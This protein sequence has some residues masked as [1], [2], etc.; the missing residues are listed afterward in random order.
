MEKRLDLIRLN[1][2]GRV[3]VRAWRRIVERF[4]S[5]AEA[6]RAPLDRLAAVPGIGRDVAAAIHLVRREDAEREVERAAAAGA[7]LVA[8]E[9]PEYPEGLREIH[10][11]PLV[12][13]AL[14]ELRAQER[15]VAI[16]GARRATPYGLRMAESIARGLAR[17]AVAV[18]SG[19][20]RGI[21]A[22]AH[23]GAL[24]GGGRTIAVLGSGL[25]RC[26]PPEHEPLMREIAERGAVITE[27]G[28]DAPPLPDHFPRRNRIISA[29]SL[30]TVIAEAS[31]KSGSLLTA[32]WALEQGKEVLAVPH[33]ADDPG[34]AGG[35]RLIREGA[36]LVECAADVLGHLG[37]GPGRSR[38]RDLDPSAGAAEE[39]PSGLSPTEARI[40]SLLGPD[41]R[42][43][44]E[45]IEEAALP[46]STVFATLTRLER[47]RIA[48]GWPG[49][50]YQ[51]A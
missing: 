14:G 28:L 5:L 7:R 8:F 49:R 1:L 36:A 38:E 3:G 10:D 6:L 41:P 43:I 22:A 29:I 20:A 4:G 44:D 9:D 46:A 35:N 51:R 13:Y 21:D 2:T 23:R 26:Y 42:S 12:L 47:K 16:V 30:G 27:F 31:A 17:A 50:L 34:A 48:K 19:L 33:R 18:V 40:V 15:A 25:F 24:A 32:D 37:L 11:P 39:T 45:I